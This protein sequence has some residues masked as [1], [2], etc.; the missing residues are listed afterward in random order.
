MVTVD[1]CVGVNNVYSSRY[2]PINVCLGYTVAIIVVFM[3]LHNQN[4]PQ[5]KKQ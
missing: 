5:Y 4:R 3:A 1:R 2:L